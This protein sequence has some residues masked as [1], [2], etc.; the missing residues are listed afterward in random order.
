M[1]QSTTDLRYPIGK[2][3]PQ[4]FS[5]K[6]KE[7]WLNDIKFLPQLLENAIVNLDESQLQTPYR[8][9]GWTVQQV[10]HHVADSHMNGYIRCKL[11]LTEDNPTIRPYE[12]KLWANLN[13][14]QQVPV[15]ISITL[16]YALHTRWHAALSDLT[17]HD[18]QRKL[19]H[20]EANKEMTVWYLLGNYAWHGKHHVA[21]IT[22][23]RERNDW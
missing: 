6:L 16:L 4:P 19:F 22:S 3:E 13:D 5:E 10:A 21:H 23:L 2:Y 8:A 15:N 9:G 20:P 11:A 18:W 7:E 1:D 12:E 14:V 17:I